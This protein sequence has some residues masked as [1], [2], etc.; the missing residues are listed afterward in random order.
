MMGDKS[1]LWLQLIAYIH[2]MSGPLSLLKK[3]NDV[4]LG[5]GGATK[6]VC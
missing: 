2:R 1:S 6:R 5:T 4:L 3:M